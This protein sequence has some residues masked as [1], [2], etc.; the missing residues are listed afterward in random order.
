MCFHSMILM[1]DDVPKGQSG[2]LWQNWGVGFA[3][4]A[5]CKRQKWIGVVTEGQQQWLESRKNGASLFQ[6]GKWE[7]VYQFH[8]VEKN[9]NKILQPTGKR[10]P[11]SCFSSSKSSPGKQACWTRHTCLGSNCCMRKLETYQSPDSQS[12]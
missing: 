11:D 3:C 7:A 2:K 6:N 5:R 10:V 12:A 4:F 8:P 9:A 1:V